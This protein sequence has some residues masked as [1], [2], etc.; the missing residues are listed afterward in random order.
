MM[1]SRFKT[2]KE[3]HVAVQSVFNKLLLGKNVIESNV[4]LLNMHKYS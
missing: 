4:L 2:V 3:V 1:K